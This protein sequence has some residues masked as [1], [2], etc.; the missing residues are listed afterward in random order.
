MAL[1]HLREELKLLPGSCQADGS[2]TWL[3]Q[4]PVVNR[5]Y[6]IGWLDFELLLR[7]AAGTPEAVA[8]EVSDQTTLAAESGDV[9]A[10]VAFLAQNG[11][12]QANSQAAVNQLKSQ[13]LQQKLGAW[14][15]LLHH[16]LFFRIPLLYPQDFLA[17]CYPR[18]AWIYT[19]QTAWSVLA[20]SALGLFLAAR[21]W[22][23][24]VSTLVDRLSLS[25]LM[26]Y[27][28]AL[29][30]VKLLH[31]TGHALTAARY[32]V[33][34]AHMGVALLVMLPMLYTDTSE[35]WKL[36]HPR[37]RLAIAAAGIVTEL[38]VA[39]LAT[40]GW[41]L[42]PPGSLKG[43]MFFLA[44]TSWV[45]TLVI[46]LSPFM[47]FDGYFML[48]DWLDFPNLHERAGALARHALRRIMLGWQEPPPES[49]PERKAF[50]LIVFAWC[51][52]VYRVSV[53][54]G[55]AVVVYH[56]FFKALGIFMMLLELIWFVVRPV[57]A[58]LRI[59][60]QGRKRVST[61]RGILL[62]AGL[63]ILLG[64]ALVP[65]M[66]SV[67]A[68]GM[69][70]ASRHQTLYA[71]FAGQIVSMP[72]Q[73]QTGGLS[74]VQSGQILYQLASPDMEIARARAQALSESRQQELDE[75]V[76]DLAGESRR[77]QLLAQRN[78]FDAE[79]RMHDQE[80]ARLLL[81]APLTGLLVDADEHLANGVWVN[82]KQALV[83]VIDPDSWVVDAWVDESQIGALEVGQ[84]AR[85]HIT[86]LG[87]TPLKGRVKAV[88]TNRTLSLP[89]PLLSAQAG[90]PILTH[91]STNSAGKNALEG[92]PK[93]AIYRV[94]IQIDQ[95]PEAMQ[96]ALAQ[97][98][99]ETP[100]RSWLGRT[101]EG[102][103]SM[104]IRESGF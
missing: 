89:S 41:S 43:M 7:W 37:Q 72:T 8:T 27:M 71:P 48:M 28:G 88:D 10:L 63:A 51:T 9:D 60:A 2:P 64:L 13:A 73:N 20:L 80:Q 24:F 32:G 61:S 30:F 99:I 92:V 101:L 78:R 39:G 15:W 49:L 16:Y 35:S 12:L 29:V 14:Q 81:R 25:G 38:S 90:G 74:R 62:A 67:H 93:E 34:V 18:L 86:S 96:T 54:I 85:V 5:F 55:I 104:L 70:H 42:A 26:G 66:G 100:G 83:T 87:L 40:L 97:V 11:L 95:A 19:A 102:V 103:I 82:A 69:L 91:H 50:G 56:F 52:W 58:E 77:E 53:F 75:L 45:L 33:R 65:W 31:E 59:W 57:T 1:P 47:R 46:N 84:L 21:Q 36:R 6:R 22:D 76:G 68:P 98:S 17:R 4:D 44:T 94:R 79:A 3:L 23:A